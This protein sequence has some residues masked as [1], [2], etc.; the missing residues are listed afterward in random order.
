MAEIKVGG[1]YSDDSGGTMASGLLTSMPASH[2]TQEAGL[3]ASSSGV[4]TCPQKEDLCPSVA[5]WGKGTK[6]LQ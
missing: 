5:A 4:D 1:I 3:R 2:P 6:T